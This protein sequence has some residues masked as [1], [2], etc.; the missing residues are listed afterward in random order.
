MSR[1]RLFPLVIFLLFLTFTLR[2]GDF[3]GELAS[4]NSA[5]Q[6]ESAHAFA[7]EPAEEKPAEKKSSSK[8]KAEVEPRGEIP[9]KSEEAPT[10]VEVK[11]LEKD[12]FNTGYS[13]EEIKILQ[14]LSKRRDQLEQ[15]ERDIDQREKLLQA[16]EKKVDEKVIEMENLRKKIEDLLKGQ[17][18]MQESR[19]AQLVKIY[20]NMKP[21][22][23]A[24]IFNEMEFDVLLGIIDKMSERKVAPILAAMEPA[25]AREVSA[26]LADQKALPK[27]SE[28]QN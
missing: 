25:R 13:D 2:L 24:N 18:D 12:P 4:G 9:A 15:R 8:D 16:A 3:I 21:K 7:N 14:S 11:G 26:K 1:I 23:A 19:I 22:D 10:E 17:Q 27:K 20:E 6:L 28:A 5:A